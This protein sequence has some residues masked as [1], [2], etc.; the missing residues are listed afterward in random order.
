MSITANELVR[1][2]RGRV[3]HYHFTFRKL[4]VED[5]LRGQQKEPVELETPEPPIEQ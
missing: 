3:P 1:E 2:G 5:F 4:F